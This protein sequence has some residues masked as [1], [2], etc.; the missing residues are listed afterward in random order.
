MVRG[1]KKRKCAILGWAGHHNFGDFLVLRGLQNLFRDWNI[2]SMNDR[3]IDFDVVNDCDLFVLGGG[4]LINTNSLFI[5]TPSVCGVHVPLFVHRIMNRAKVFNNI[6]WVHKIKVPKVILGCGVNAEN[7]DAIDRRVIGELEQ[8]MYIGLRDNTSVEMLKSISSLADKVH[9]FYDTS[10]AVACK[11]FS[12]LR[13]ENTAVVIPTDRQVYGDRGIKQINMVDES[14]CW[15]KKKLEPFSSVVFLPFGQEDND[16]YATCKRLLS[17]SEHSR[18]ISPECLTL[19]FV[20]NLIANCDMIFSYRLHGLILAF[21]FD[22]KYE[23]YPYHWKLDRVSDTIKGRSIDNIKF[24]QQ[25]EFKN[26]L[27]EVGMSD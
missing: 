12:N 18:I 17:C 25:T 21:M 9:L 3:T 23:F 5:N 20:T 14:K 26:M 6:S 11:P 24:E 22:K 4:E 15:L 10:F 8:F 1:N 19:R 2:I 7:I 13:L 27:L 16:D